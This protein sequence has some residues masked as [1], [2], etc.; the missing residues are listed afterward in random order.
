MLKSMRASVLLT[1]FLKNNLFHKS[2]LLN[3]DS[4]Y[5]LCLS[6]LG[7]HL[8]VHRLNILPLCQG[9]FMTSQTT[10]GILVYTLIGRWTTSLD[11]IENSTFIWC[12]S[13]NLPCNLTAE[14][15]PLTDFL[16]PSERGGQRR[17]ICQKYWSLDKSYHLIVCDVSK[18]QAMYS[19]QQKDIS[20]GATYNH[21]PTTSPRSQSRVLFASFAVN[22]I[23]QLLT[24]FDWDGLGARS[25]T[26]VMWPLL[27]PL[28]NPLRAMVNFCCWGSKWFARREM[29]L[30]K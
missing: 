15:S 12:K 18:M 5:Y 29:K 11:H 6:L 14:G 7:T 19:S 10:L 16:W 27:M 8:W 13:S 20:T 2:L 4:Q 17:N 25:R 21:S 9:T 30:C 1:T 24:P 26:V 28:A 22:K 23:I 3:N